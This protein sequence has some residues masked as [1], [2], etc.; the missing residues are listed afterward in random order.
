MRGVWISGQRAEAPEC[1][2]SARECTTGQGRFFAVPTRVRPQGVAELVS[3]CLSLAGL[4]LLAAAA[5]CLLRAAAANHGGEL[6]RRRHGWCSAACCL[7]DSHVTD[8]GRVCAAV[9][10]STASVRQQGLVPSC[11]NCCLGRHAAAAANRQ[12]PPLLPRAAG[13]RQPRAARDWARGAVWEPAA[14][15]R[16]G[17]QRSR[18]G[19][20][21]WGVV[22]LARAL[23][24]PPAS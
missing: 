2:G 8:K 6:L 1:A 19:G 15:G 3:I 11:L 12:P 23:T 4:S 18:R 20:G 13:P 9:Q 10:R 24:P 22:V 17:G 7:R 21:G 5:G 16:A 14:A